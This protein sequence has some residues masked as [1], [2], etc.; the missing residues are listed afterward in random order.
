MPSATSFDQ[1]D[2]EFFHVLYF[3]IM[4]LHFT[5]DSGGLLSSG[6]SPLFVHSIYSTHHEYLIAT[7]SRRRSQQPEECV[8]AAAV[9]VAVVAAN[10]Q[11]AEVR[12]RSSWR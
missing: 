3:E 4:P 12:V 5:Q 7:E 1:L 8:V 9:A 10:W 11:L 6:G 2:E